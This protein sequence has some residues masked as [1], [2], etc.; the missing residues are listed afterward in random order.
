[1][2]LAI[3]GA[4]G[5]GR[6]AIEFITEEN[7]VTR[8]WE[9]IV[10]VDDV[11]EESEVLGFPVFSFADF[12]KRYTPEDDVEFL[13]SVGDPDSRG[14][15]YQMISA[16]GYRF[17]K[18]ISKDSYISPSCKIGDGCAIFSSRIGSQT[19]IGENTVLMG[20]AD[21]G[22][23][24]TIGSHCVLGIYAV[25]GGH[26]V[27][28][29]NLFVGANSAVRDGITVGDHSIVALASAILNDVPSNAVAIGN[30]ARSLPR[31]T[32]ASLFK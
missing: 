32:G 20:F 1:M 4:G 18:F 29:N 21:V 13:I 15:V 27:L 19:T 3:F 24:C 8:Q 9:Q 17:A 22:H 6:A 31:R 14:K 5:N 28:G 25:I 11:V 12:Q 10:F 26:C 23:D 2:V 30:P 7:K 16:A